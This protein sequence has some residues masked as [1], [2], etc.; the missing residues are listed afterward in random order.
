MKGRS[1]SHPKRSK[2]PQ[3]RAA[4][5]AAKSLSRNCPQSLMKECH[6]RRGTS[7]GGR[8]GSSR[9]TPSAQS[10]GILP[11]YS[12]VAPRS[13]SVSLDVATALSAEEIT[14]SVAAARVTLLTLCDTAA[15]GSQESRVVSKVSAPPDN[16]AKTSPH[17]LTA[18][19]PISAH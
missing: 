11:S 17:R 15:V 12:R 7:E 5:L 16:A 4:A 8:S 3:P 14:D 10:A 19:P 13:S 18:L 2:S 6:R 9:L 1:R